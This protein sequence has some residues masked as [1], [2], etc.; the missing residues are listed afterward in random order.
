M[1]GK[2]LVEI[3]R[4]GKKIQE[5]SKNV[6]ALIKK[7]GYAK[8]AGEIKPI[9]KAPLLTYQDRSKYEKELKKEVK[10]L[11]T[12][13]EMLR[14]GPKEDKIKEEIEVYR[15]GVEMMI[16][17]EVAVS[18]S[19]R[20]K[21]E[22]FRNNSESEKIS[23]A[24]KN[25]ELEIKTKKTTQITV[26]YMKALLKQAVERKEPLHSYLND[27]Y[28]GKVSILDFA[29]V[30]IS[31]PAKP[32]ENET[33]DAWQ[34]ERPAETKRKKKEVPA[35]V[36]YPQAK[37]EKSEKS[38][39]DHVLKR[40]EGIKL[41]IPMDIQL[42][43]SMRNYLNYNS[44]CGMAYAMDEN[45]DMPDYFP[46]KA[47]I[48]LSSPDFY[49]KLDMDTLFFIF[50]FHQ[51]TPCQYY[52]ARELKNYSWRYHTKYMAWFQRLEEPSIITEDYEQGTYIF[53]DY[54]V[55]WS[56]RKKENFR[57]DYKYLEDSAL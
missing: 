8:T 20:E 34:G 16:E 46:S 19:L 29:N 17:M 56:S 2:K 18:G 49:Q 30:L 1:A 32:E 23:E 47:S 7:L 22:I 21:A 25:L 36:Q 37:P 12:L 13:K 33:E 40:I 3:E 50:Y 31:K 26:E 35:P 45:E 52:A 14:S 10:K 9:P 27:Y 4:T 5:S 39:F 53:F 42:V 15:K 44:T 11:N 38:H 6:L 48:L 55:S 54:E 57:F 43:N 51:N 24:L 41:K 28:D